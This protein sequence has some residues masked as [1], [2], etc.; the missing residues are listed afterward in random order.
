MSQSQKQLLTADQLVLVNCQYKVAKA[1]KKVD[2]TSLPCLAA[3]PLIYMQQMW[4]TLQLA[5]SKEEFKS[6]IDEEEVTFLL[7]D[8]RIVLKLTQA[9]DND[10]A[11]FVEAP[12]LGTMIKFLNI[13]GHWYVLKYTYLLPLKT[14]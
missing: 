3:I 5:N 2:L 12:D 6:I 7:N 1:N 8:L 14:S 9:T 11:E 4:N 10:H 13:L